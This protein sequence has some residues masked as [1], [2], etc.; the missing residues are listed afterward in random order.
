MSFEVVSAYT[1]VVGDADEPATVSV[2]TTAEDAWKALDR[3]V[4]RRCRM[5]PRPRRR[6]DAEAATRL[7]NAW[8]AGDPECRYWNV[9]VHRL[10]VQL[11]VI[12]REPERRAAKAHQYA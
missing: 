3:E 6:T 1:L 4:R 9:A 5:R 7:A 12:A 2:H 8:R 10:P 11:P